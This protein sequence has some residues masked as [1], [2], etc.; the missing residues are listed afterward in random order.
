TVKRHAHSQ[1]NTRNPGTSTKVPACRREV[2]HTTEPDMPSVHSYIHGFRLQQK[3]PHPVQVAFDLLGDGMSALPT[4]GAMHWPEQ[5]RA[6]ASRA[7]ILAGQHSNSSEAKEERF[8][9]PYKS[10]QLAN[11]LQLCNAVP[12]PARD[13]EILNSLLSNDFHDSCQ[14]LC[15]DA[16]H[17]TFILKCPAPTC[18]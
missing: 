16:V 14:G 4:S 9:T 10:C 5:H 15:S 8:N 7:G 2:A 13:A 12:H 17:Q 11:E 6:M 18:S 3:P 1:P